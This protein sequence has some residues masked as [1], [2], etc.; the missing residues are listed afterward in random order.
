MLLF[1]LRKYVQA[2]EYFYT[3]IR[4]AQEAEHP[5]LE[6]VAWGNLSFAWIYDDNPQEAL[7]CIQKARVLA[8]AHK[9][10]PRMIQAELASRE[11]EVFSLLGEYD[12]CLNALTVAERGVTQA[13]PTILHFGIHFGIAR[14]T[15]YQ[16]ACLRRFYQQNDQE[17]HTFL[18]QAEQ[19]LQA[20]LQYVPSSHTN[21]RSTLELDLAEV[22]LA[23]KDLE[24]AIQHALQAA[25]ITERTGSQMISQRLQFFQQKMGKRHSALAQELDHQLARLTPP[26][27]NDQEAM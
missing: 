15:G 26:P 21:R 12:A 18:L 5:L 4:A 16:G 10:V 2:R 9:D 1:D 7:P 20:A 3:A 14:W 22:F 6:T 13:K 23:K 11:A 19:A 24:G 17:S 27:K 8:S 25:M